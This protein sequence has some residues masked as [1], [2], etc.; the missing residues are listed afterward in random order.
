MCSTRWLVVCTYFWSIFIQLPSIE[1]VV[2]SPPSDRDQ[3]RPP[4]FVL[5]I[6]PTRELACQA[7]AEATKLLK[8]HPTLGVQVVIGGTRLTLEQKRMQANPCQVRAFSLPSKLFYVGLSLVH[9][10]MYPKIISLYISIRQIIKQMRRFP[11]YSYNTKLPDIMMQSIMIVFITVLT[12]SQ[13][14][15]SRVNFYFKKWLWKSPFIFLA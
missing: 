10:L 7:A 15:Y 2:K 11:N 3:R 4:I 5:V 12:K 8:Y 13:N 14:S 1:I 6:C 9:I